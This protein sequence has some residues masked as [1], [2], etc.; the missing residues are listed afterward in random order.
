MKRLL[1]IFCSMLCISSF[2]FGGG[3]V[4]V[5]LMKKRFADELGW[6][7]EKETL[8]MIALAQSAPGPIAVNAAIL[9]GWRMAGL[10]GMI[11]AVIGTIIPPLV[12][13]SCIYFI[14]DAFRQNAY[15]AR[16][17]RGMQAGVAAV[18]F[19]VVVGLA[20]SIVKKKNVPG[21]LIAAAA[22]AA[23]LFIPGSA[24]YVVIG[25]AVLGAAKAVYLVRKE[26]KA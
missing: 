22:L 3:F 23:S 21:G 13:I 4:I 2:T 19:S 17:M 5:S 11:A 15:V 10:G 26:K 12:I 18:L 24:M 25:A 1:K 9:F 8:D 16:F 20:S 14:Y 7:D 6:V